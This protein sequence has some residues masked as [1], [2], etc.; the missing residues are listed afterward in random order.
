[1]NL[2]PMPHAKAPWDARAKDA[3][4]KKLLKLVCSGQIDLHVVQREIATDWTQAYQKYM[5][6]TVSAATTAQPLLHPAATENEVWVNTKS[7]KYWKPGSRYYGKTKQGKY[8]PEADAISHG[9]QPA[10]GAGH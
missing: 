10:Y 4:E 1:M 5:G 2:W 3:L 7:G 6:R 9:Y 8:M